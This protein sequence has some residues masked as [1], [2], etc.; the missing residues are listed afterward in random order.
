[1]QPVGP[2]AAAFGQSDAFI[3]GIMG[4]VGGGKTTACIARMFQIGMKQNAIWDPRRDWVLGGASGTGCFVRKCRIAVVRD[5][6]PNLDRTTIKSWQQWVPKSLGRWVGEAPRTHAFTID[7]QVPGAK[8]HHQL[9][10]EVIF[11]AIGDRTV[12]DVLRGLELTALWPNEWDLLPATIL[13][14]GAGRVGRY[15][16]SV[17]GGCAFS[18]IIGDFN[19]PEEDNHLVPLFG[20]ESEIDP[21][22]SAAFGDGGDK[23]IVEFFRQPGGLDDGAEN[24]V[25]LPG[26]RGYYVK[27]AAL[28]TADKKR[29]FIDNRL[30]PIRH[31]TPVYP[32]FR[33][34]YHVAEFDID[35]RYPVLIGADQG[36]CPGAVIAQLN[37]ELDCIDVHDE[38]ARI[39]ENEDGTI[40]LSQMG[41]EAFGRE[42]A[43]RLLMR[44]PNNAIGLACCD[45]AGAAGE[46][47]IEQRSWRQDFQKGL[48]VHVRKARV[49]GNALEPR[50]N[51]MRKRL[52]GGVGGRPR[53]RLHRRCVILRKAFNTRYAWQRISA[54][55]VEGGR[56]GSKP[57]KLQGYSDVMNAMEYL[58]FEIDR[59]AEMAATDP[60]GGD[61]RRQVVA[62]SS[63]PMF[64][65][66]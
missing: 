11:T 25:N 26:G 47:A 54:G 29:R 46:Q 2:V 43:A 55:S 66:R 12:E 42:L 7:L 62:D 9:D 19:A 45:P 24:L 31:G 57:L 27:Q 39:F 4:P 6:Y 15:P 10:M 16:G 35:P 44:A 3:A 1:M 18:Q 33:D 23:P 41:G 65:G 56:F 30:G 38:L 28:L 20:I 36:I 52:G 53:F 49:P 59:G 58:A 63:Y 32:E 48:G 37:P 51:A 34:E 50:L 60:R 64:G 14:I 22:L 21:K 8:H 61:R 40:E 13:Q 5:T 17:D